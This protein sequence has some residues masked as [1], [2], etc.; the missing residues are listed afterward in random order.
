MSI[1]ILTLLV[2]VPL[3]GALVASLLAKSNESLVK[4]VALVSSIATGLLSL[5][6]L[7]KFPT[8]SAGFEFV[9]K[10]SWVSEWGISWHLGVDGISLFLVVLTGILFPLVIVGIDPGEDVTPGKGEG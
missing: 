6:M 3:V 5:W 8:G 10:H 4:N 1:P 9:S 2:L 7:I